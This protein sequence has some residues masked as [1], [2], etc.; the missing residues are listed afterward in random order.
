MDHTQKH[1][2]IH[3]HRTF[4]ISLLPLRQ[5]QSVSLHSFLPFWVQT[6]WKK[7]KQTFF[8]F[9]LTPLFPLQTPLPGLS[10][11]PYTFKYC[12][13]TLVLSHG[14][15]WY[16]HLK[17]SQ[18]HI[19]S[20]DDPLGLGVTFKIAWLTFLPGIFHHLKLK[21]STTKFITFPKELHC[22]YFFLS[23]FLVAFSQPIILEV[24][25]SYLFFSIYSSQSPINPLFFSFDWNNPRLPTPHSLLMCYSLSSITIFFMSPFSSK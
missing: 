25:G 4:L 2:H 7:Q 22:I 17:K 19:L 24:F 16:L 8:C 3:K 23:L 14:L 18:I 11:Y 21:F 6:K 1:I 10:S 13:L 9:F 5:I 12:V 20:P 15:C